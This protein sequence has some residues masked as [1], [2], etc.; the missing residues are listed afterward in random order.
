M[1]SSS[2]LYHQIRPVSPFVVKFT[3]SKGVAEYSLSEY[4][5]AGTRA[6]GRHLAVSGDIVGHP[7]RGMGAQLA[8]MNGREWGAAL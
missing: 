5:S 7:S 1:L 4:G 8:G 3:I 6:P 2:R